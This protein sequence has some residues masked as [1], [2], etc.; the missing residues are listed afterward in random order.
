MI[1]TIAPVTDASAWRV[2]QLQQDESWVYHFNEAD[3]RELDDALQK[4]RDL[5][6]TVIRRED[7]PLKKLAKVLER[8]LNQIENGIGMAVLRGLPVMNYYKD[9]AS[10]IYWGIGQYLGRAVTQNSRAHL[11]G[12]VKNEGVSYSHQTR[13]YNTLA[14]LNF[15]TDNCDVVGLL[16]LRTSKTGGLS[17]ISSS[18]AIFNEILARRPEL[19]TPLLDGFYYDLKGEHLP[20]RPPV[21]DH[22]IPVYSFSGG[23][24]SCRYLRNAIMPA[25]PKKNL[26]PTPDELAAMDMIDALADSGEF[27]FEMALEP[28]DMQ[29]L[30]NHVIMHS[31]TAFEDFEEEDRKRHLLRLWLRTDYR[32][33]APEFSERFGPGTARMGVPSPEAMGMEARQDPTTTVDAMSH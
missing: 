3:I 33:L 18:T 1:D 32:P 5:A 4:V 14:K 15:H 23:K 26:Q 9:D 13:G 19:I 11:L 27:C 25:F 20:G 29:L 7:F 24:L 2:A 12:H 8:V 16:C 10:R 22:K 21:S 30:N 28:G 17:R 6:I 31:R